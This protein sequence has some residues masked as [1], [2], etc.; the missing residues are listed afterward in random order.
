MKIGIKYVKCTTVLKN[1]THVSLHT[2][3]TGTMYVH[4]AMLNYS[5]VQ[6]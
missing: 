3:N 1:A 4:T 2:Q 6:H 5:L